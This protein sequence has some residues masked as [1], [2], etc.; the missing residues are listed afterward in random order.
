MQFLLPPPS[1]TNPHCHHHFLPILLSVRSPPG[2]PIANIKGHERDVCGLAFDP[3]S[4]C[5]L[6]TG[7]DD[8]SVCVWDV[9]FLRLLRLPV[10]PA[11]PPLPG[12]VPVPVPEPD[13]APGGEGGGQAG[14]RGRKRA[15]TVEL[16]APVHRFTAHSAAVKAL[17]WHP[18][19]VGRE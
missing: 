7:S 16:S 9:R 5:Q 4:E 8:N 3:S 11:P 6:A 19:Q 13:A 1:P 14:G 12:T 18:K 17:A 2:S 15:A 10:L